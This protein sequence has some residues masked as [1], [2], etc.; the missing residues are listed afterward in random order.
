MSMKT[1]IE[2]YL[3]H[4]GLIGFLTGIF[5]IAGFYFQPNLGGRGLY[6]PF[7]SAVWIAAIGCI[8]GALLKAS[9]GLKLKLPQNYLHLLIVPIV[10][11][12]S[13]M[14]ASSSQP[15]PWLFRQLFIIG[16]IAFLFALFQFNSTE[17]KV[18]QAL[19]LMIASTLIHALIGLFQLYSPSL[20]SA[21]LPTNEG[22]TPSGI[23]QQINVQ[24]TYLVTGI[25]LILFLISRPVSR[26]LHPFTICMLLITATVCS[27]IVIYSGSRA[28]LLSLILSLLLLIAFRRKQLLHR[29]KLTAAFLIALSIGSFLGSQSLGFESTLSKTSDIAKGTSASARLSMYSIAWELIQKEPLTGHGIGNYLRAWNTQTGHYHQAHPEAKIPPYITHP[30]NELVYWLIE[31]GV[32]SISG[33]L[34]ALLTI[35]MAIIKCGPQRGAGYA[36]LL[37]PISLHAQV[38]LP[39]YI[40]STHWFLWLFLIFM[41]L[42]H[43]TKLFSLSLSKAATYLLQFSSALILAGSGYFLINSIQ[44]QNDILNYVQQRKATQPYLKTALNNIYFKPYAEELAMRSHLYRSISTNDRKGIETALNWTNHQIKVNPELKLFEDLIS[45]YTA[46]NQEDNKCRIIKQGNY[47]YPG[48]T[49]LK[50]MSEQCP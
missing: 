24:A 14:L 17:R 2:K 4:Y 47:M 6:L 46:L 9:L 28:G 40:S 21:W 37:L 22:K 43:Q 36:A 33:I 23:F 10:I 45:A 50:T 31:G 25:T 18:N 29:K 32:F 3:D 44:S 5:L 16:G 42:R 48:N 8:S 27:F 15:I 12:L 19:I 38:E 1:K 26:T 20:I 11:I 7:N 30:H 35:S 39:F 13:G 49:I 34:L 41:V